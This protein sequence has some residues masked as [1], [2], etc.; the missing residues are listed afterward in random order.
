[1]LHCLE[2]SDEN[3]VILDLTNGQLQQERVISEGKQTFSNYESSK[4]ND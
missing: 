3:E 2:L 4:V 1:M